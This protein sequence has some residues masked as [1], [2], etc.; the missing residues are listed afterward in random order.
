MNPIFEKFPRTSCACK[1]CQIGCRTMPG[2]LGPGDAEAIAEH[3]GGDAK[4]PEWLAKHFDAS[5]GPTGLSFSG[6][7]EVEYLSAPTMVPKSKPDGSCVFYKDGLCA[8]H[9]VSPAG[10][11]LFDMHMTR[12][13]DEGRT[14][15]HTKSILAT[16]KRAAFSTAAFGYA[17]QVA[18]LKA[19]GE[20][21][22]TAMMDRRKAFERVLLAE[23]PELVPQGRPALEILESLEKQ[24]VFAP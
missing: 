10:C 15:A 17:E 18:V 20:T 19:M 13:S 1:A 9:P 23:F 8:I 2:S 21:S 22:P 5:E 6:D 14:D 4:N 16:T 24:P 11:A 12:A 3:L 7:G